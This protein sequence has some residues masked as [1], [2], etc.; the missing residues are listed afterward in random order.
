MAE[1]RLRMSDYMARSLD[2]LSHKTGIDNTN[3]VRHAVMDYIKRRFTFLDNATVESTENGAVID[4]LEEWVH[5]NMLLKEI[6]TDQANLWKELAIK[7][8]HYMKENHKIPMHKEMYY[9][10]NISNLKREYESWLQSFLVYQDKITMYDYKEIPIPDKDKYKNLLDQGKTTEY[11]NKKWEEYAEKL[12]EQLGDMANPLY[13]VLYTI[14]R[15]NH[16]ATDREVAL[17]LLAQLLNL[18]G[19]KVETKKRVTGPMGFSMDHGELAKLLATGK[20]NENETL[21][22]FVNR[23]VYDEWE[24]LIKEVSGEERAERIIKNLNETGYN[25]SKRIVKQHKAK[26]EGKDPYAKEKEYAKK[27]FED[28]NFG[29]TEEQEKEIDKNII[30]K[31]FLK[32]GEEQRNMEK[33][34]KNV[35]QKIK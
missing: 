4:A 3:L 20:I 24:R 33:K 9:F 12:I 34:K 14:K 19:L 35:K 13:S 29:I 23:M 32:L 25:A 17:Y 6:P 31:E 1:V 15:E 8:L 27:M 2:F 16:L 22:D 11:Y 30:M 28:P 18:K 26:K 21:D 10:G 7:T 5:W